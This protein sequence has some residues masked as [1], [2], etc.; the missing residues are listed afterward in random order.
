VP[1]ASSSHLFSGSPGI[2]WDYDRR[3]IVAD[4]IVHGLGIV[5]AP[6]AVALLIWL[7]AEKV[8]PWEFAAVAL[9]GGA[10][11]TVL[12]VSALYNLWPVSPVKWAL[13]RFDHSAIYLLIAGTYTP[14]LSQMSGGLELPLLFTGVWVTSLGGVALKLW[15]PGRFES[16]SIALYLISGWSGAIV[17]EAVSRLPDS[18]VQLLLIGGVLYTVG[19]AFHMWRSLRF[20]NAIWH[21]FVLAAASCHY[22]AVLDCIVLAKT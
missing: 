22:L 2:K 9:Y 1:V 13:R 7:A 15:F 17:Y 8:G 12:I 11:A 6:V 10:L 18:T 3:E 21:A 16:L 19:T 4:G 14:V 5:L 20:Q